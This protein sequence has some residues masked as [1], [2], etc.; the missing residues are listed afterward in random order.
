MTGVFPM[1]EASAVMAAAILAGAVAIGIG[2]TAFLSAHGVAF[3]M[4]TIAQFYGITIAMYFNDHNPPHFHASYG[5]ETALVAVETGDIFAGS[6]P[7]TAARIVKDWALARRP[8]LR[9]NWLRAQG[10]GGLIRIAG[11]DGQG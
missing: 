11:P 7:R 6:L 4:P 9:D 8:E 5:G 1:T 3:L 2:W 10:D